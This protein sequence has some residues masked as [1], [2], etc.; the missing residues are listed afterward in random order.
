MRV[1]VLLRGEVQTEQQRLCVS[2]EVFRDVRKRMHSG[3]GIKM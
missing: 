3:R 1:A 2:E